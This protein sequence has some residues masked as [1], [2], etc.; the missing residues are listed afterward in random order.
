[1]ASNTKATVRGQRSRPSKALHAL[2]EAL[3]LSEDDWKEFLRHA[4][5]GFTDY[6][7]A[8]RLGPRV[9]FRLRDI[10]P[11]RLVRDWAEKAL[12]K[13]RLKR[14]SSSRSIGKQDP[15]ASPEN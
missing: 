14:A 2:Q 3:G 9:M 12:S 7:Q 6:E 11:A 1:M 13:D 4:L 5:D 10:D 8:T 15:G